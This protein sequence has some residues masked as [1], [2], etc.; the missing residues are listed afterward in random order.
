M[1]PTPEPIVLYDGVCGLCDRFVQFVLKRD[2]SGRV[3][4]AQLQSERGKELLR[5]FGLPE[6]ELSFVVLV[7]GERCSVK[8][9]A[10]L[11][12]LRHLDGAWKVAS[13]L[14]IVPRIISD[15]V[16]DVVARNR[17]SWF[18]KYDVCVIPDKSMMNRFLE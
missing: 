8:S 11:S 5:K 6:E 9:S 18:G 2:S 16:Y 15:V 14:K 4:F 1:S 3:K 10:V 12:T 7:E 13:Y 17:Y